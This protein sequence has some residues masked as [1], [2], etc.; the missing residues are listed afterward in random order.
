MCHAAVR[1]DYTGVVEDWKLDLILERARDKGFRPEEMEDAQQEL[2]LALLNFRFDPQ[3]ANGG[4]ESS[5][6]RA[7]IDRQLA[8]IQRRCVRAKNRI[9]R[10]RLLSGIA[11]SKDSEPQLEPDHA[12]LLSLS[13][14]VEATVASLSP[15]EKAVCSAI[16]KGLSREAIAEALGFS[17]Y[18]VDRLLDRIRAKFIDAGLQAGR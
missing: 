6:I 7:L 17:R 12:D 16:A 5:A 8:F 3:K 14:D 4:G 9:K 10:Y 13:A 18:E 11:E 2:V 15:K 1:N